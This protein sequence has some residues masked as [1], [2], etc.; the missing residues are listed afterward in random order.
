M[1][2]KVKFWKQIIYWFCSAPKIT[3]LGQ[4]ELN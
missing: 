1:E 2:V 4:T 3:K